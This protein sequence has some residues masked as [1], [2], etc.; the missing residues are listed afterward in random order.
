MCAGLLL[1]ES[2]YHVYYVT[3]SAEVRIL[4]VWHAERGVGPPLRVA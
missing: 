4:A 3:V 2:R 1:R